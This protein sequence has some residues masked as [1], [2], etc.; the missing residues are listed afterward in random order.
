[1][2]T[3]LWSFFDCLSGLIILGEC[4]LRNKQMHQTSYCSPLMYLGF[5]GD[6]TGWQ[7]PNHAK[8]SDDSTKYHTEAKKETFL[9][10]LTV[11]IFGVCHLYIHWLHLQ[12]QS[13]TLWLFNIAMERSTISKFGKPSING[14]FSMAML[15]NQRVY[16]TYSFYP[17]SLSAKSAMCGFHSD[18]SRR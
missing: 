4:K 8:K 5:W 18:D 17:Q 14:S 3:C 15:N 10:V 7:E 16:C 12:N 1:M 6:A 11:H 13:C 2:A 9:M